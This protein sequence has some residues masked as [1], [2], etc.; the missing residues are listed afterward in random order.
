MIKL[1]FSFFVL[2]STAE[3]KTYTVDELC[4][5]DSYCRYSFDETGKTYSVK[6]E[7][8]FIIANLHTEIVAAGEKYGVDP[9]AIAGAIAA[10][11]TLNVQLGDEIQGYLAKNGVTSIAGKS[12]S[13][14]LGQ[15]KSEAAMLGE[16]TIAKLEG[17]PVRDQYQVEQLMLNPAETVKL[18]AGVIRHAQDTY[19]ANGIDISKQP[20]ILTTLYNLGNPESRVAQASAESPPRP[21]YFGAFV[22]NNIAEVQDSIG[23]SPEKGK[24]RPVYLNSNN[25]DINTL[26]VS[27]PMNLYSKPPVCSSQE[28]STRQGEIAKG[29]TFKSYRLVGKIENDYTI[30][31]QAI[32]CEMQRWV[33]VQTPEGD[34]GWV[35]Q[36]DLEKN[37]TVISAGLATKLRYFSK[38]SSEKLCKKSI[39]L[40]QNKIAEITGTK[41]EMTTN[42]LM[43]IIVNAP[44]AVKTPSIK[45]FYSEC[46][47]NRVKTSVQGSNPN[48]NNYGNNAVQKITGIQYRKMQKDFAAKKQD[49]LKQANLK[50]WSDVPQDYREVFDAMERRLKDIAPSYDSN[51]DE[52]TVNYVN[53][54]VFNQVLNL[55]PIAPIKSST[56]TTN[57]G[58]PKYFGDMTGY[59]QSGYQQQRSYTNS[60]YWNVIEQIEH[61]FHYDRSRTE[62]RYGTRAASAPNITEIEQPLGPASAPRG[63]QADKITRM[64]ENRREVRSFVKGL[65]SS[66]KNY[67]DFGFTM[68]EIQP[69]LND[70][71]ANDVLYLL[72]DYTSQIVQHCELFD[73]ISAGKDLS[74]SYNCDRSGCDMY[75]MNM[76]SGAPI[77]DRSYFPIDYIQKNK[78]LLNPKEIVKAMG[79][80]NKAEFM[81]YFAGSQ[82]A[83]GE[84]YGLNCS[85]D[86]LKTIEKIELL[87]QLDCVGDIF[88]PEGDLFNGTERKSIPKVSYRPM[89]TDDSYQLTFQGCS[90]DKYKEPVEEEREVPAS[91][92][93]Q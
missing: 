54:A 16:A 58:Q 53:M 19:Q 78:H 2:V 93:A 17:R 37:S 66:C 22:A 82:V 35:K 44:E 40:C 61:N 89:D 10:E 67:P 64:V 49:I 7:V 14:G 92:N 72:Q 81:R 1:F 52:T 88:V 26:N 31:D 28:M 50:Q 65:E 75:Y 85:Y 41:T 46:Y 9:R 24:Y 30:I 11:N 5:Y 47:N 73:A 21:N 84:D 80:R 25:Y 68:K 59:N 42:G 55:Q 43:K 32:D 3:N 62:W 34:S 60:P 39:S 63:K 71:N 51:Y 33:L 20:E 4:K 77:L 69:I 57:N 38:R 13:Y 90:I 23:W 8:R 12:F 74:Y 76:S 29:Q 18:I 79:Q 83:S 56:T 87:S 91:S 15:L 36:F 6:P 70:Q 48:Q 86:P 45:Q 27:Q